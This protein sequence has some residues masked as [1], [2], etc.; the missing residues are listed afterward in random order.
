MLVFYYQLDGKTH[1]VCVRGAMPSAKSP[2]WRGC[3]TSC[4]MV[5]GTERGA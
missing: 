3:N 5:P 2:I 4:W 1:L